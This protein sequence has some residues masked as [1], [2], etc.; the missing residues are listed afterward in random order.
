MAISAASIEQNSMRATADQAR[1]MRQRIRSHVGKHACIWLFD[2]RADDSRRGGHVDVAVEPETTP[3]L[4]ARLR[5]KSAL[6]DAPDL[7]QNL[8]LGRSVQ[9]G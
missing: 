1:T 8:G 9:V 2:S 4:A 5:R 3:D 7:P 6:A